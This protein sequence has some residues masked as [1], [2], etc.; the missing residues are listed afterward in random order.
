MTKLK[1]FLYAS[2][3]LLPAVAH[4]QSDDDRIVVVASGVEQD[5]ETTGRSITV[6]DR[7]LIEARQTVSLSDLLATTPGVSS[8]RNGGP[9]GVTAVR[10]R[11]AEDAQTLVLIDGVRAN[12]PRLPPALS[13]SAIC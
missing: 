6:L 4:A 11:G 10:I 13:T 8:T 7:D 9:G 2:A 5:A 3:A 1:L 12:D